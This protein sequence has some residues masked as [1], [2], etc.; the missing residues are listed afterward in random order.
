MSMYKTGLVLGDIPS[1]IFSFQIDIPVFFPY[2]LSQKIIIS[3]SW[4]TIVDGK[5]CSTCHKKGEK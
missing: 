3:S 1:A 5:R 2:V 4:A